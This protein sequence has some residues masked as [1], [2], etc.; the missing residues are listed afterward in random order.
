MLFGWREHIRHRKDTCRWALVNSLYTHYWC[1][2]IVSNKITNANIN[3]LLSI[4]KSIHISYLFIKKRAILPCLNRRQYLLRPPWKPSKCRC[5]ATN[6]NTVACISMHLLSL[7]DFNKCVLKRLRDIICQFI[8]LKNKYLVNAPIPDR[9]LHLIHSASCTD[10]P[11][12]IAGQDSMTRPKRSHRLGL[13]EHSTSIWI[14]IPFDF[15][16]RINMYI[17]KEKRS[18]L[19]QY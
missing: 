10:R 11:K 15:V 4:H 6:G 19:L 12:T 9:T 16:N 17:I 13:S 14:E 7:N 8:N 1:K 3:N 2:P 18:R 5:Q